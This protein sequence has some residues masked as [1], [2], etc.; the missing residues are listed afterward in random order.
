MVYCLTS[1]NNTEFPNYILEHNDNIT[2]IQDC[3]PNDFVDL[4]VTS[5]PYD[6]AR[7]YNDNSLWSFDDYTLLIHEL[8]RVTKPGGIVFWVVND[9]TIDGSETCTSFK[10]AIYAK[11][12][13]GFLLHDTM[14]WQK[15]N[16]IPNETSKRYQAAFEYMFVFSKGKPKTFNPIKVVSE[17]YYTRKPRTDIKFRQKDG[18]FMDINGVCFA[19]PW[20]FHTNIWEYG[21]GK[22][23]NHPAVFPDKLARDAI[24]SWSNE[25]DIVLDPFM[26]SGTTGKMAVLENRKFIGID[27]NKSYI[28]MAQELIT[29]ALE[30]KDMSN[31]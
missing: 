13:A 8:Y 5:P 16:Y 9:S 4:T 26:G 1:C 7:T 17:G 2:Y 21:S 19:K 22:T 24:I 25:G 14:I 23:T 28:D 3:I 30:K 11:E 18:T 12:S 15:L 31:S 29:K 20:K 6:N 27:I 10:Q